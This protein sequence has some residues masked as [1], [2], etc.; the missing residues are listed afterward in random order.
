MV[1]GVSWEVL[2]LDRLQ[3]LCHSVELFEGQSR[4][5][6]QGIEKRRRSRSEKRCKQMERKVM[7][8]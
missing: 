6:F 2:G 7:F 8:A 1:Y 5:L 4:T 3:S